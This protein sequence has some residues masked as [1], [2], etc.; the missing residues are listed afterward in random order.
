MREILIEHILNNGNELTVEGCTKILCNFQLK[1]LPI[2]IFK[3]V[4]KERLFDPKTGC[5]K[6]Q[7][8]EV[9]Y[10]LIL[11]ISLSNP[12]QTD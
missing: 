6:V 3:R 5:K 2:D 1:G 12:E 8:K 4:W 11:K 7:T 9:I 10:E